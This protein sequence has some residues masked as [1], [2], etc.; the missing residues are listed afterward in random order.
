MEIEVACFLGGDG[1]RK[2][3]NIL[4]FLFRIMINNLI[5]KIEIYNFRSLHKAV[6]EPDAIT[7]FMWEND[8]WKSNVLKALNLF[9]NNQTDFLQ[10]L[11]FTNDYCKFWLASS[12][13]ANKQK[14][15]IKIRI[16]FNPPKS[17]KSL[18]KKDVYL[19]K[20]YYRDN[21]IS[22]SY[23]HEWKEKS[24]I[25][26]LFWTIKYVYIPALKWPNV[27][28][29]LIGLL[30][31]LNILDMKKINELN[32]HIQDKTSSLSGLIKNSNIPISAKFW[33]PATLE[34]FWQNLNANTIVDWFESLTNNVRKTPKGKTTLKL[35]QNDFLI[36][37]SNRGDWIKSKYIPPLLQWIESQQNWK[38]Y[39]RGI[40]EPENS[41]EF[42]AADDVASLYYNQYCLNNQIFFT[43]HSL[44]FLNPSNVKTKPKLYICQK[45]DSWYTDYLDLQQSLFNKDEMNNFFEKIGILEI[46]KEVM[47]QFRAKVR[48]LQE[49]KEKLELTTAQLKSLYPDKVFIC[50]DETL[51]TFWGEL[52]KKYNI[53]WV[54]VYSS[55][56]CT[57]RDLEI[58]F[59]DKIKNNSDYNPIILRQIDLGWLSEKDIWELINLLERK[60]SIGLRSYK[61]LPLPVYEIE[62][63]SLLIWGVDFDKYRNDASSRQDILA[64]TRGEAQEKLK[65]LKKS[66][67]DTAQHDQIGAIDKY[68]KPLDRNPLLYHS[69]KAYT[70]LEN[71]FKWKT[72][73][74]SANTTEI[75]L[76]NDYLIQI[77]TYFENND[78][79]T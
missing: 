52:F 8:A 79:I 54:A 59:N 9:F 66:G 77:R 11:D 16:Y 19:E 64:A 53:E 30:W 76:L 32:D 13:V 34:T 15:Q 33:L 10:D 56:W 17:Y 47:E 65:L 31:W 72:A 73:L 42:R 62:N 43:S 44:A 50:E 1:Y 61:V 60:N 40:D 57:T 18:Q 69:G 46:Q 75:P 35:D 63:F 24:S 5:K 67:I 74:L 6:I 51:V 58:I 38:N 37:L 27:L 36:P 78:S 28:K 71:N 7:W 2:R 20:V 22:P 55:N 41:L 4:I 21:S 48:E 23:S 12:K 70:K 45:N 49:N 29:Y 68:I 39:I 3:K 26:R 14:Q 25:T